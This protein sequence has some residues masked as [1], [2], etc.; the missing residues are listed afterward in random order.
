M[1]SIKQSIVVIICVIVTTLIMTACSNNPESTIKNYSDMLANGEYDKILELAYIPESDYITKEKL[2][3]FKDIFIDMIVDKYGDI[4]EC[5]YTEID[6][7]NDTI[8]YK[9]L[10]QTSDGQDT[11]NIEVRKEDNKLLLDNL[12]DDVTLT[13]YSGST[14]YI[15][16]EKITMKPKSVKSNGNSADEYTLTILENINYKLKITHPIFTTKTGNLSEDTNFVS[17]SYDTANAIQDYYF[18]NLEIDISKICS[19]IITTTF[20]NGNIT[21]LN[22]YF[23]NKDTEKFI[24]DNKGFEGIT[25][26]DT[27]NKVFKGIDNVEIDG[28]HY[29]SDNELSITAKVFCTVDVSTKSG[30]SIFSLKEKT[31]VKSY[32]DTE[33][34]RLSLDCIQKEGNWK[35]LKWDST[36]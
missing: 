10:M 13:V 15:D 20:E 23:I 32:E 16:G 29:L 8:T 21:D 11:E 26:D 25:L 36:N 3:D 27:F 35:I 2:N 1:K 5:T 22:K 24:S 9:L 34:I 7:T 4:T 19:D 12:Y 33:L 31:T 6:E 14:V 17:D 28:I 18:K 30:Q